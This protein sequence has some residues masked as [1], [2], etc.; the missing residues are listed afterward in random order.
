VGS[1]HAYKV[2]VARTNLSGLSRSEYELKSWVRRWKYLRQ[3]HIPPY[4]V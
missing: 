3:I 4:C 1:M 2:A